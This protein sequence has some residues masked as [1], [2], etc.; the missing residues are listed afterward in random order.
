M[1]MTFIQHCLISFQNDQTDY[2]VVIKLEHW[3]EIIKK[4]WKSLEIL[5]TWSEANFPEGKEALET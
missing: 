5:D 2:S 3:R 1:N 4:D